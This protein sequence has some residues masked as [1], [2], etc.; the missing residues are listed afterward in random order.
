MTDLNQQINQALC[1]S[2]AHFLEEVGQFPQV[3]GI[4]QPMFAQQLV[5]QGFQPS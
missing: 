1:P 5:G 3:M 4:A 2:L